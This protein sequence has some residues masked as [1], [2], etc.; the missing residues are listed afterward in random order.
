MTLRID[1]DLRGYID[2]LTPDEYAALERSLLAEGC[3]DALVVWGD[4]LVDGHNRYEICRKHGIPY[5]TIAHAGFRDMDDV[6]LWMIENH[7]GRRSVSDYQRGVL[8]LRK[9]EILQARADA[10][11]GQETPVPLPSR[12]ELARE[13]RLSPVALGRIEKIRQQAVPEVQRAVQA[14]GLSIHAAAAVA[15]LPPERQVRAVDGGVPALREAAREA[16]AARLAARPA[17]HVEVQVPEVADA[18]DYPAELERLARRV[19]EL[20]QERDALKKKVAQLTVALA[21]ARA[22]RG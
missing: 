19:A 22:E 16:R 9:K 10:A 3:R 11:A 17:P 18:A 14:G 5:R 8:A 13:A 21:Q 2:P 4:L 20:T 15:A 7:L 1:P 6:R 12:Q